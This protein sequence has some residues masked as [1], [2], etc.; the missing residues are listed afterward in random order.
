MA[1]LSELLDGDETLILEACR[2]RNTRRP[3]DRAG[4]IELGDLLIRWAESILFSM[5]GEQADM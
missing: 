1:E 4:L 2:S 3:S 5:E